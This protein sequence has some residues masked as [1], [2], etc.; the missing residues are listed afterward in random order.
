MTGHERYEIIIHFA[1]RLFSPERGNI[2]VMQKYSI[3]SLQRAFRARVRN[4]QRYKTELV[5]V[6]DRH[7]AVY[8]TNFEGRRVKFIYSHQFGLA[9]TV[10]R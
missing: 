2:D 4:K 8:V 3:E 5:K 1:E 9:K 10:L 7:K 6:Y